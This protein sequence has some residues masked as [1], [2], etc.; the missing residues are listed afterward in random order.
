MLRG[1]NTTSENQAHPFSNALPTLFPEQ[2]LVTTEEKQS[3]DP[4]SS[5]FQL[6]AKPAE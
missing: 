4:P 1:H 3:L 5:H 6:Q 2:V